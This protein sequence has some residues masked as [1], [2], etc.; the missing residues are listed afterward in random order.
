MSLM[1]T[2]VHRVED[3]RL[4]TNGGRYLDDLDVAGAVHAVFVR[5]TMA[6]AAIRSIDTSDARRAAGVLGVFTL[7]DL[8]LP[9]VADPDISAMFSAPIIRPWLADD[10]VRFVGEPIAVVVATTRAEAVDASALVVVDYDPRPA[11]VDVEAALASDAPLLFPEVG[12]NVVSLMGE[13][14]SDDDFFAGCEVVVRQR[15][16]NSRIAACPLETRGAISE[17][18]GDRL[19]HWTPTQRPHGIRD[20]LAAYLGCEPS[21]IRLR[22]PD[23]GGGFGVKIGVAREELVV[24]VLARQLARPVRWYE[25][26]TEA[27]QAMGHGRGQV[28]FAELGGTRDGRLLA[29][30]LRVVQESGAYPDVGAILPVYTG[31]MAPGVYRI[32]AVAFSSQSVLTNTA[33]TVAF[34]G[35]GRPE[36][37]AALERIVDIYA[38]E[39]DLDPADVRRRNVIPSD[40]FPYT[41]TTGACYDSGDYIGALDK[42]LAAV[43]YRDLRVEQARRRAAGARHLLGIGLCLYVEITNAPGGTDASTITIT[44]EG[45]AIV[46]TGASPTGQGHETVWATFV[47]DRLGLPLDRIRVVYGDTDVIAA[48]RGTMGSSSLQVAGVAVDCAATAL[49][50]R[51]R[52]LAADELEANPAD[53]VVDSGG[54]HVAGTPA[55]RIEWSA[56]ARVAA[57]RS[58]VLDATASFEAPAPTFPFGAQV[59]VVEVDRETGDVALVRLVGADDAGTIINPDIFEGQLHGGFAQGVAQALYEAIRYDEGGNLLTSSFAD[60]AIVA[61]SELPSFEVIDSQT[62]TPYNALGVK[63]VGESGTIGSTPAVQNAVVDALSHLG[64]RHIDMPATPERVFWAIQDAS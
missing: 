25:T 34:R 19:H 37:T 13:A 48:G 47:A 8:G 57:Q 3:Q 24:A 58:E 12:T 10:V 52:A 32:G 61:A 29:Y 14:S 31:L 46:T 59:A 41:T 53:L 38:A 35:A 27:M 20:T 30:R 55:R 51:A 6:H 18:E 49:L 11:V 5:S 16:V 40:S 2:R 28:Q 33:P 21:A 39:I 60:Y 7:D 63:G 44:T 45:E 4:L 62:T 42:A 23:V 56:L 9:P 43:N 17:W 15:I 64:I 50:E 54:L 1:G 26:R 22:T 36:A